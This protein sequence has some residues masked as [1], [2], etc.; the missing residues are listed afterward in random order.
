MKSAHQKYFN[1]P[2][3]FPIFMMIKINI[4]KKK[5]RKWKI[6]QN[7]NELLRY[8]RFNKYASRF[9]ASR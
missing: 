8:S 3:V 1:L 4:I 6:T 9:S 7:I 5:K 2:F